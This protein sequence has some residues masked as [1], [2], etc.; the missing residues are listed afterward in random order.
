[1][2]C[3]LSIFQLLRHTHIFSLSC[4]LSLCLSFCF[5]NCGGGSLFKNDNNNNNNNN[6]TSHHTTSHI[7]TRAPWRPHRFAQA[8]R[9]A[10][11]CVKQKTKNK[12]KKKKQTNALNCSSLVGR[13]SLWWGCVGA[14]RRRRKRSRG[15]PEFRFRTLLLLPAHHT[16]PQ[17]R[18]SLPKTLS[19]LCLQTKIKKKHSQS[20]L[21]CSY[22]TWILSRGGE[23]SSDDYVR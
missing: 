6:I 13:E 16:T 17:N 1:M 5:N 19:G 10:R 4:S 15:F 8:K 20:C 21:V 22:L 3:V 14:N 2:I 7:T 11:N 12:L 23:M 18:I 9:F